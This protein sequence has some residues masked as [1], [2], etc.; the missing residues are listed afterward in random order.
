MTMVRQYWAFRLGILCAVAVLVLPGSSAAQT[1]N[2]TFVN[3]CIQQVWLAELAPSSGAE[4]TPTTGWALAPRCSAAP[5]APKICAAGCDAN[6]GRCKCTT[7]AECRFGAPAGTQTATCNAGHCVNST[8]LQIPE[9]WSGR[10]WP[11][12]RCSGGSSDFTCK[13]GQCGEPGNLDCTSVNKSANRATLFEITTGGTNGLDN[14]DVSLVSGYNLPIRVIP[15]LPSDAPTWKKNTSFAGQATITQKIDANSFL[16]NNVGLSGNSG[17]TKPKFPATRFAKVA[18]GPSIIWNNNGPSCETAGCTSDL[19]AICPS[20]LRVKAGAA[21]IAC[22]SPANVCPNGGAA[23]CST[24]ATYYACNNY[25]PGSTKDL[26][27]NYLTLQSPNGES[28]VCFSPK[29]CQPGTTC[30]MNPTFVKPLTPP[31]PTGAGV[32]TPVIQNGGCAVGNEGTSCAAFPFVDYTCNTLQLSPT[33]QIPVCLPPTTSGAGEVVWNAAVWSATATACTAGGGE[34]SA[35]QQ[36][37]DSNI[38]SNEQKACSASSAN[39]FCNN[40]DQCSAGRGANDGCPQPN[41]CLNTDGVPD[42]GSD[43][44]NTVDCSTST[45][46]CAPQAIY[47]GACGPMNSDW[48]AAAKYPGVGIRGIGFEKVFKYACPTAYAYQFDDASSD[49]TCKNTTDELANYWVVFCPA[50]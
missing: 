46:Y 41:S 39:C 23:A 15:I 4:V 36:C 14:Y 31:L 43:G 34:C 6:T 32:C 22:D 35:G 11:R 26:F 28:P 48:L 1:H 29:D 12:T 38:V 9:G 7:D 50:L 49:W 24:N 8:E 3:R 33:S 42:G 45:C 19:R 27:G 20:T 37:L 25:N 47:S 30:L 21:T 44:G 18:D 13:T 5:G 40:P 2:I 16:F 10:F 17:T